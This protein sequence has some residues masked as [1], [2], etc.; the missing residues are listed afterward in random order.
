MSESATAK[1]LPKAEIYYSKQGPTPTVEVVVPYG[2][3][4]AQV[5]A[6]HDV[7]SRQ[8]IAKISPRG[9]QQCTSGAHLTIREKLEEVIQVELP[10][11]AGK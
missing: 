4:L 7:I 5:T 10:R 1:A 11:V 3:T 2:T 9:C 8:A 6:L